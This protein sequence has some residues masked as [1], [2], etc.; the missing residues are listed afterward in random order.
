M[1]ATT[2]GARISAV[3]NLRACS[4][5]AAIPGV[6]ASAENSSTII[7]QKRLLGLAAGEVLR[8]VLE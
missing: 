2:C 1:P 7:T 6:L 4:M 3:L 8:E 5:R